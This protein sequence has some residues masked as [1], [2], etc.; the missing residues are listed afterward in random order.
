ME[1]F[2][3]RAVNAEQAILPPNQRRLFSNPWYVKIIVF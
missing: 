1:T 2:G 3:E